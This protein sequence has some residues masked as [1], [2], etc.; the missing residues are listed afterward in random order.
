VVLLLADD[1]T[2]ADVARRTGST[3]VQVSRLRRRF[4]EDG[5]AGLDDKPR[6]GRPPTSSARMRAQVMAKTRQA[7]GDGVKRAIRRAR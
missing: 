7:P 1:V 3:V 2:G 6:S 4:A 5:V